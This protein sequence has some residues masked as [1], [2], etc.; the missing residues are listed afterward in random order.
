MKIISAH[1]KDLGDNFFVRR[2]IPQ[3]GT[4]SIG[5]FVFV[6]HFGPTTI[7]KGKEMTVRAHPHIGLATITYLYAGG[8]LHR[9]S[10]GT[11]IE[12]KPFEVNWMTAGKGIVHSERSAPFETSMPL[13]GI[14]TW[15][16][17]PKEHEETEP[18][19]FHYKA[20]QIPVSQNDGVTLRVIAGEYQNQLSPVKVYSSLF[21]CDVEMQAGKEVR[22]QAKKGQ[23]TG[24]YVSIGQIQI[25][26]Q[27]LQVGDLAILE[28]EEELQMTSELESRLVVF[29]GDPFPEKRHLF[30][31]FVSSS[32]E[33]IEQ[34]KTDWQQRKFPAV[35]NETEFIP[36]PE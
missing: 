18:E 33:K 14:Q 3:I 16:A 19:F 4:K 31:N 20:D 29:G 9:D 23:Q 15:V 32:P 22:W 30:W 28:P 35:P 11:E 21:Y 13:Q 7:V 6:D 24:V 10:L 34:A 8:I 17:L 36:L 27:T 5:P 25:K 2:A 26:G 1:S 12:I